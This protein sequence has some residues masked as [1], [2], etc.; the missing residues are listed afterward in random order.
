MMDRQHTQSNYQV[1]HCSIHSC[2]SYSIW[3]RNG[4][5][6]CLRYDISF[7]IDNRSCRQA[8]WNVP[9]LPH[10]W[11]KHKK[12]TLAQKNQGNCQRMRS[13]V[14]V[15]RV[16]PWGRPRSAASYSCSYQLGGRLSGK[17]YGGQGWGQAG[18]GRSSSVWVWDAGPE[19]GQHVPTA[20]DF[21]P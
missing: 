12:L 8:V 21:C 7:L 16:R 11:M 10:T 14:A 15:F 3:R 13:G 18:D 4:T 6:S 9:Y 17:C 19:C 5:V 20:E 1:S 2:M